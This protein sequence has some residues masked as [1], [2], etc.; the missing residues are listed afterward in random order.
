MGKSKNK[1]K[2]ATIKAIFGTVAHNG[3]TYSAVCVASSKKRPIATALW[4]VLPGQGKAAPAFVLVATCAGA[5]PMQQALALPAAQV[6]YAA[7]GR[8]AAAQGAG[9]FGL[10]PPAAP[11]PTKGGSA[12]A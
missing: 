10:V 1:G 3:N 7:H 11:A 9:Q 2:G 8:R 12:S 4:A 6:C 5:Q